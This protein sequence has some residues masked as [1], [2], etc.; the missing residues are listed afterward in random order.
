MLRRSICASVLCALA[1]SAVAARAEDPT[2]TQCVHANEGAQALRQ[3]GKL[4]AARAQLL[5][6]LAQ[7]C[8]G[9]VRDDC[10]ERMTELE[11]AAP[12]IVFEAKDRAGNALRGVHIT[13][14]DEQLADHLDGSALVVDPR[15]H[16]FWIVADGYVHV[17]KRL[18][19]YE[20]VKDRKEVVMLESVEPPSEA[21]PFAVAPVVVPTPPVKVEVDEQ[22]PRLAMELFGGY[23]FAIA[24]TTSSFGNDGGGW[25]ATASPCTQTSAP[26]GVRAGVTG[27]YE[28]PSG[29]GVFVQGGYL[30][31]SRGMSREFVA[32]GTNAVGSY[33]LKDDIGV[34]GPFVA[35][36]VGYRRGFA[37]SFDVQVRLSI[38]AAFVEAHDTVTG[39]LSD[40]THE[41]ATATDGS[42][43]GSDAVMLVA[44]PEIGA[45][46]WLG[47][48]VRLSLGAAFAVSL[49]TG[50]T[51]KLGDTVPN[52]PIR[53]CA[54][55]NTIE[56]ASPQTL[57]PNLSAYGRFVTIVPQV[58]AGYWF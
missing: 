26:G 28:F 3:D 2:K 51:M 6:C 48:N 30:S 18:F 54:T 12:T 58:T 43:V 40:G 5:I 46:L 56:C 24:G 50:P 52:D 39:T 10:A 55:P 57:D 23:G 37:E 41:V 25:C 35:A 27:N 17:S 33:T 38:G 47:Q 4:R 42:G 20:G 11:R 16:L 8:P 1:G 15:Q 22:H 36:G 21:K 19:I 45:G 44:T 31:L 14:D 13:M 29:L 9:P 53:V 49:L 34:S 7:S 32:T